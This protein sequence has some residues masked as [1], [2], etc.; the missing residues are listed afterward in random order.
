MKLNNIK[1]ASF[2]LLSWNLPAMLL[3]TE[4]NFPRPGM[5]TQ[6]IV[7]DPAVMPLVDIIQ[8]IHFRLRVQRR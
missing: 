3:S 1:E 5:E 4:A 7:P 6:T 2:H 8:R